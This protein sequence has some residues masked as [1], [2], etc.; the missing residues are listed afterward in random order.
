MYMVLSRLLVVTCAIFVS[1]FTATQSQ[2]RIGVESDPLGTHFTRDRILVGPT[3]GV[4]RNYH[5]GGFRVLNDPICPIFQGGSGRGYLF[6]ITAEVQHNDW[7]II[8]RISYESRPGEFRERLEDADV[9][10]A[11]QGIS[12]NQSVTTQS[13]VTYHLLN[14]EVMFKHD[15]VIIGRKIR[16]G[17]AGGPVAGY[18]VNGTLR[19]FQD[20]DEPTNGRF[21]NE[22]DLPSENGGRRLIYADN[23]DI[24][25]R[26][27]FRF[28]LKAGIQGEIGLY[29]N[30][31]MMSPGL[32]YDYGLSNVTGSE[33]WDLN[34]VLLQIDFRYAF[35]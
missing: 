8:P 24:P 28:S 30:A 3:L 6:G 19:Q 9:F 17:L 29:D 5:T 20:L 22:H 1:A 16:I 31:V 26:N 15:I 27:P 18:V 14:A 11:D 32:Y 10:I 23:Q 4:N 25:G 13:S 21:V 34:T 33:N 35:F 12:V 2:W 7:S